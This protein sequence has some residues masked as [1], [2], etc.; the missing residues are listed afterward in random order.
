[1]AESPSGRLLVDLAK[2]IPDLEEKAVT[3]YDEVPTIRSIN[4]T[5]GRPKRPICKNT[6]LNMYIET[7]N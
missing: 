4:E 2:Y 5:Q 1:M 3:Y 7:I 6:Y